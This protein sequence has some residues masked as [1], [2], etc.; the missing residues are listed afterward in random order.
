MKRLAARNSQ[1][2][3]ESFHIPEESMKRWIAF[4]QKREPEE[5]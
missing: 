3:Q 5:L 2:S 1:P 4:F